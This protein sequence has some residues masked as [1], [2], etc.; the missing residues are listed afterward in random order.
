MNCFFNKHLQCLAQGALFQGWL[1]QWKQDW[2]LKKG[3][4]MSFSNQKLCTAS[5]VSCAY[6]LCFLCFC[7]FSVIV[8]YLSMPSSHLLKCLQHRQT[9]QIWKELKY[10]KNRT[11]TKKH[12]FFKV[13]EHLLSLI[14]DSQGDCY[15]FL[16]IIILNHPEF[17]RSV[18]IRCTERCL[19]WWNASLKQFLNSGIRMEWDLSFATSNF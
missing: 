7:V 19:R 17:L 13:P 2:K 5:P 1:N 8:L 3:P 14:L 15:E 4:F 16:E 18:D 12:I 10:N 6:N 11:T 9:L